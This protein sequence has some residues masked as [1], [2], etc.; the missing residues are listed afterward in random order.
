MKSPS[1]RS[2]SSSSDASNNA[3]A[4]QVRAK[5]FAAQG[6]AGMYGS[7][8]K[9]QGFSAGIIGSSRD[10]GEGNGT[11][12]S[13]RSARK[14]K[15]YNHAPTSLDEPTTQAISVPVQR[16]MRAGSGGKR[17]VNGVGAAMG[18]GPEAYPV[19]H[20]HNNSSSSSSSQLYGS[21]RNLSPRAGTRVTSPTVPT[22]RKNSARGSSF[23]GGGSSTAPF[24]TD[25]TETA[26]TPRR[27]GTS[28]SFGTDDANGSSRGGSRSPRNLSLRQNNGSGGNMSPRTGSSAEPNVEAVV[29][30][31]AMTA[32]SVR[33]PVKQTLLAPWQTVK[34]R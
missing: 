1:S 34:R 2:F 6:A 30:T 4:A 9:G 8:G 10:N 31:K 12:L 21:D 29:E 28:K 22:I 5:S 7:V 20:H 18:A 17:P 24:G 23:N 27:F 13:P 14:S 19:H 25:L 32:L 15:S 33:Q 3:T 26:V 11:T 16:L